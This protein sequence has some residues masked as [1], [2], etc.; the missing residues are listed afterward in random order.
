MGADWFVLVGRFLEHGVFCVCF[1][2]YSAAPAWW[3]IGTLFDKRLTSFDGG[4]MTVMFARLFGYTHFG[5]AVL[6]F[7]GVT[8]WLMQRFALKHN[9]FIFFSHGDRNLVEWSAQ[10]VLSTL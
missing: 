7:L 4:E 5:A 8:C 3:K 10:T 2:F 1:S 9:I 6:F